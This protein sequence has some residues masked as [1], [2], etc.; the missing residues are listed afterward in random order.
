M[1]AAKTK[2]CGEEA[3]GLGKGGKERLEMSGAEQLKQ[4]NPADRSSFHTAGEG[5]S[6]QSLTCCYYG[7]N[8]RERRARTTAREERD[9][10]TG[11]KSE[12]V[13]TE[14]RMRGKAA[15]KKTS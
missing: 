11:F 8:H 15:S 10:M 7:R 2:T 13:A 5:K 1:K 3:L 14:V 6:R 9:D 4:L 12:E